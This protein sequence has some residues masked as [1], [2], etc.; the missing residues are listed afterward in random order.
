MLS[1]KWDDKYATGIDRIDDDHKNLI[2]LINEVHRLFV[3]GSQDHDYADVLNSLCTYV[4][5]HFAYEETWMSENGY[6]NR[7]EHLLEHQRFSMKVSESVEGVK[8]GTGRLSLDLLSFLRVWLLTHIAVHDADLGAFSRQ[9][10]GQTMV[11]GL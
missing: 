11:I 2:M 5:S 1:Q 4:A 10:S 9:K 7:K 8:N 6:P 3:Y